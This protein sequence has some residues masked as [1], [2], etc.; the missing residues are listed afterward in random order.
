MIFLKQENYVTVEEV[1][2]LETHISNQFNELN[3]NTENFKEVLE[4]ISNKLNVLASRSNDTGPI[5]HLPP[6]PPS[7]AGSTRYDLDFDVIMKNKYT[8]PI[9]QVPDPGFFYG[10]TNETELFC[11]VPNTMVEVLEELKKAFSNIASIKLAKIKMMKLK[12][13]EKSIL[14]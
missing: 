2:N 10:D 8:S 4:A 3:K 9:N 13:M 11:H 1:K 7:T 5:P 6:P 14:E 12:H